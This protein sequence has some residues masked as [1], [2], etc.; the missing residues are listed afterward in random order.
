MSS[1]FAIILEK[2][3]HFGREAYLFVSSRI[4]LINFGKIL[5]ITIGVLIF[6]LLSLRFYTRHGEALKVGNFINKNMKEVAR[7]LDDAG[8][9]YI[10]TDSIYKEGIAADISL[11]GERIDQPFGVEMYVWV[12][13][14]D[15]TPPTMD[16]TEFA[17]TV[18]KKLVSQ[19]KK[20]YVH[21]KNGHGRTSTILVAFFM[22]TRRY[23]KDQAIEF[24]QS[25]RPTIHLQDSQLSFLDEFQKTLPMNIQ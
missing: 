1:Y 8:F 23:T 7:T 13:I 21:C 3:K 18:L 5:A 16:Q 17:V 22:Q 25:K 2:L 10:V 11:E 9:S 12:P 14:P 24:I 6:I 19:N 20:I 4:F 15:H